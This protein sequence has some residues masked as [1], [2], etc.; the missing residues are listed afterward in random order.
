VW[1]SLAFSSSIA[2]LLF[3]DHFSI[4]HTRHCKFFLAEKMCSEDLSFNF[5]MRL[6]PLPHDSI[7]TAPSKSV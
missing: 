1:C 6:C 2:E 4:P 7:F 3:F 5:T